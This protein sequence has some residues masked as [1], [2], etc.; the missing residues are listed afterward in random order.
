MRLC[1]RLQVFEE[2][3]LEGQTMNTLD[4]IAARR[5]IRKFKDAAME[6]EKLQAIL[7]A[8]TQAPS[9]KNRQPW[10][11]VVVKGDKR[12]E[13]VRIM[14]EG[15][16]N[17][18]SRGDDTGSSERTV[19]VMERAPATVFIFNPLGLRPWQFHSTGQ[20]F[21]DVVDIQS[22]GASI[23]NMLLAAQDLGIGSLWICDIFNAYEE[24]CVWLG[25]QGE[26]IAA[27]ALGYADEA[28]AARPRKPVGEVA[29]VM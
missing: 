18:K 20:M 9:G 17:S 23:Q 24:L 4:A 6:E 19:K 7:L 22:I 3:Y 8:A 11:F 13:M 1:V 27:V 10:R 15:I 14:K 25:G 16:A 29:R 21:D 2:K 26:M 5:S 12:A 28:P